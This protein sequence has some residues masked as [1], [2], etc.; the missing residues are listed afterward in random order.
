MF[1]YKVTCIITEESYIGQTTRPV[2]KRI[3]EHIKS[4]GC[5]RLHNAIKKYGIENFTIEIICACNSIEELDE[6]EIKYIKELNTLSP[7]GYNLTPGGMGAYKV[8]VLKIN[9]K[10]LEIVKRYPSMVSVENDGYCYDSVK[11]VCY[12]SRGNY[13]HKGFYWVKES[14]LN[15]FKPLKN[16]RAHEIIS[17]NIITGQVQYIKSKQELNNLHL[18]PKAVKTCL[19]NKRLIY[20]H[21]LWFNPNSFNLVNL[22]I[23][24]NEIHDPFKVLNLNPESKGYVYHGPTNS[25]H[26]RIKINNKFKSLGYYK[27]PKDAHKTYLNALEE[28]AKMYLQGKI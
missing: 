10:T 7:N 14:E 11:A 23:K 2:K 8:P 4:T 27:N 15:N 6:M 28:K 25:F 20:N 12:N 3:Q 19:N 9:K 1:I 16:K 13:S 18:C 21:C 24:F 17:Y 22:K 5:P 26:A